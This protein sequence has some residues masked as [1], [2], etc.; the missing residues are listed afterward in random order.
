MLSVPDGV[1]ELVAAPV[2]GGEFGRITRPASACWSN[3]IRRAAY[4]G[5]PADGRF[6]VSS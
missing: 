5:R 2:A 3:L 4:S 6:A 1:W